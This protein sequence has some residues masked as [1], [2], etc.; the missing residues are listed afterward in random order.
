MSIRRDR[1]EN[2][3][4]PSQEKYIDKV[5]EQFHMEKENHVAIPLASHFNLS[6]KQIPISEI[7]KE[8]MHKVCNGMCTSRYN[9]CG[10]C[11]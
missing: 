5:L 4:C 1:K 8:E 7:E 11:C 2:K 6:S 10:W 9:T 3:L